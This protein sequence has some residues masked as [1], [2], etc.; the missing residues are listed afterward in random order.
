MSSLH[1]T[2][3]ESV[4]KKNVQNDPLMC[5]RKLFFLLISSVDKLIRHNCRNKYQYKTIYEDS[6][7]FM[8]WKTCKVQKIVGYNKRF[9]LCRLKK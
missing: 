8:P 2:K 3:G 6:L 7:A 9:V 1:T 4:Y 5:L